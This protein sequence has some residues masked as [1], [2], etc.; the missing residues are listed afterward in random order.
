MPCVFSAAPH[1]FL[2]PLSITLIVSAS[3]SAFFIEVAKMK[4]KVKAKT[5]EPK[6]FVVRQLNDADEVIQETTYPTRKEA[7][8][9]ADQIIA[10]EEEIRRAINMSPEE[11]EA[12][13]AKRRPVV[14]GPNEIAF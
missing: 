13:R 14:T 4:L 9:E 11:Q 8:E 2:P 7:R 12:E 5:K 1:Y 6:E 10:S 3:C